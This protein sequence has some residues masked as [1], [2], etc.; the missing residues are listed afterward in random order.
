M[1]FV[2]DDEVLLRVSV[3]LVGAR[4]EKVEQAVRALPRF[5]A[6]KVQGV[7]FYRLTMPDFPKHFE[8][9]FRF[10]LKTIPF[11]FLA[12]VRKPL[13]AFVEFGFNGV[14][15]GLEAF[16]TGHEELLGVN[17]RLLERVQRIPTDGIADLDALD[18]V[19]VE[20]NTQGVVPAWHPDVDHFAT[21]PAFATFEVRGGSPILKFNQ[22]PE[23]VTGFD[24]LANMT[25]QMVLKEGLWR[26]QTV[27]ARY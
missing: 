10:L 7:V 27:D 18:A 14:E 19:K 20:N 17:P 21:D 11:Q 12:L 3:E 4:S 2:H 26:V 22:F 5:T 6:I 13:A 1:G 9:V 16:R 15:S 8:V 24:G 23:Q 25:S